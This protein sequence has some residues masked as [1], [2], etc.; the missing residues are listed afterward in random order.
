MCKELGLIMKYDA[1]SLTH[2]Q[3]FVSNMHKLF[4]CNLNM[5]AVMCVLLH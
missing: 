3:N 1:Q 2:F 5:Y 4:F